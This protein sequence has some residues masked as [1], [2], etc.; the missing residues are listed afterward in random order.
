[1][2][3]T[4]TIAECYQQYAEIPTILSGRINSQS[5]TA[6]YNHNPAP[7]T[8]TSNKST[9][10]QLTTSQADL[11]SNTTLKFSQH[12]ALSSKHHQP[13]QFPSEIPS[14]HKLS[15]VSSSS[16]RRAVVTSKVAKGS[17]DATPSTTTIEIFHNDR[18]TLVHDCSAH[19]GDIHTSGPFA[20]MAWNHN[21][22]KLVYIAEAKPLP[23]NPLYSST[24]TSN[25]G[26]SG[27]PGVP[28]A[29]YEY[30]E[31]FGEMC[32]RYRN[33][34]VFILTVDTGDVFCVGG[35]RSSSS[36]S[37]A[38]SSSFQALHQYP[39]RPVWLPPS[40]T[41]PARESVVLTLWEAFQGRRL[42]MIYYS[43]RRSTVVRVEVN[44]QP[45]S[46]S[47]FDE[48]GTNIRYMNVVPLT[49]LDVDQS[50]CDPRFSPDGTKMMYLTSVPTDLHG[51]TMQV[52]LLNCPSGHWYM[53]KEEEEEEEEAEEA[54]VERQRSGKS[55]KSGKSGEL[56]PTTTIESTIV[57]DVP[58]SS[59]FSFSTF[60]GLYARPGQTPSRVWLGNSRHIVLSAQHRS[61]A[62]LMFIDT[63]A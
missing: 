56:Q 31:H 36:A 40:P 11:V 13:L 6:K 15:A 28:G 26:D 58:S 2:I 49:F 24:T 50:A 39:G 37:S 44:R 8:S 10:I 54:N 57:V 25:R 48:G 61:S 33:P 7:A 45:S 3:P 9:T 38:S 35:H 42:G 34:A 17:T 47:T 14:R 55:G 23:K 27:V 30:S 51:S 20:G 52:K 22:T 16:R 53:E 62:M 5:A 1:M 19:H 32:E 63:T 4:K 21:E 29:E 43:S 59:S 41:E 12:Y 18:R 46:R 60:H